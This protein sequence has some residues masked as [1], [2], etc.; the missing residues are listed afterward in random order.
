[1]EEILEMQ[2]RRLDGTV[3]QIA[4]SLI[5]VTSAYFE[6]LRVLRLDPV[7]ALREG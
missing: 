2:I 6:T 1:M 7:R 5:Y 3:I 4:I